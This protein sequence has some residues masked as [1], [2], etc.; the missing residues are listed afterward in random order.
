MSK[1]HELLA[2]EK[3]LENVFGGVVK[4]ATK[5]FKEKQNMFLG[6]ERHL[7]MLEEGKEP[8]TPPEYQTM[9][10]TVPSKLAYVAKHGAKFLNAVYQKEATN[11]KAVADLIVDGN[12]IATGVPAT[13]LLGLETKLKNIRE[14]YQNI[15]TLAPGMEWKFDGAIEAYRALKPEVKMKTAKTFKH[16][17]LYEATKE[18][19][20]QIE[21]WEENVNVGK[22]V[23]NIWCGALTSA[24]KS[25]V[26]GHLDKM[27]QAVKKARMRA[28]DIKTEQHDNIGEKIFEY[29]NHKD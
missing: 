25:R 13:F 19:P 16:K 14:M 1:L 20:A 29:I 21:K 26:L 18:H 9:E 5:T 24:E 22:Y 6:W 4:E 3:D 11:Q 10:E 28:N 8:D 2:V 17:V 15:P 27:I 7:E 23:R 12:T